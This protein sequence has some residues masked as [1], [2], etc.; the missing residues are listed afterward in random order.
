MGDADTA[1]QAAGAGGAE[2]LQ[3]RLPG[4]DALEDGIGANAVGELLD[5]RH[6]VVAALG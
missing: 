3:H 5:P 4:A 1:D 2:S 6:P